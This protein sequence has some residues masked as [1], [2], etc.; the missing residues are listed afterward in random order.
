MPI[1][2]LL[3]ARLLLGAALV[4]GT[5][6]AASA[7]TSLSQSGLVGTPE[8]ITIVTDP[9]QWPKTFNEAPQLAELVK[10]G[11]LPP[12]KD[13]LPEDLMVIKPL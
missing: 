13:R 9:A 5:A 7:Q 2:S 10:Q 8:G 4:I 3:L 11:K 12:V 6:A 1:A